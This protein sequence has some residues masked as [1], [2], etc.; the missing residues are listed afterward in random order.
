MVSSVLKFRL[1]AVVLVALTLLCGFAS[2]TW[3]GKLSELLNPLAF[4]CA[5]CRSAHRA[6]TNFKELSERMDP[7][8]SECNQP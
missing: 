2:K 6:V 8:C 7:T 5:L 3:P 1:T 4:S